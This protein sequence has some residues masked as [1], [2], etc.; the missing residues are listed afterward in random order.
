ME[1]VPY[2]WYNCNGSVYFDT[3]LPMSLMS[4]VFYLSKDDICNL[5]FPYNIKGKKHQLPDDFIWG[6][7]ATKDTRGL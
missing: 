3:T 2:L 7:R 4:A 6:G 5:L 1:D